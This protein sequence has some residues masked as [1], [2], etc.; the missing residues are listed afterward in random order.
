MLVG[1][2]HSHV[3]VLRNFAMNPQPNVRITLVVDRPI[4]VY[5]GMVPGWIAGDYPTAQVEID[6]WTLARRCG[7]RVVVARALAQTRNH[8]GTSR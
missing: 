2:G 1:G 7:A 5:S 6:T 3:Q 4:A 8:A